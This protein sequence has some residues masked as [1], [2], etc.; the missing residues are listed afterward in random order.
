MVS[1]DSRVWGGGDSA[2]LA[3]LAC[4]LWQGSCRALTLQA[5]S[6]MP[7]P[8]APSLSLKGW[9]PSLGELTVQ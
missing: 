3:Q 6:W 7:V 4:S 8:Q 1:V 5:L 2:L 9:H